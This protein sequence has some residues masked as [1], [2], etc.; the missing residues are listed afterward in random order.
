M[1]ASSPGPAAG[2]PTVSTPVAVPSGPSG[3]GGMGMYPPMLGGRGG[4]EQARRKD[5]FP[6]KRVVFRRVPNSEA[7]F[8]ELAAPRRARPKRIAQEEGGGA[9][10]G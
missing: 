10:Q 7:V 9:G 3:V 8:G 4:E 5:L 1:P 2:T 6:D